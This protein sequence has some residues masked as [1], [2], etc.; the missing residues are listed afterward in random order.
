MKVQLFFVVWFHRMEQKKLT[1]RMRRRT[2]G[3]TGQ[4]LIQ[5]ISTFA[6]KPQFRE[7]A[8]FL[9]ATKEKVHLYMSTD[10]ATGAGGV[11]VS[12]GEGD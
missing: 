10:G 3:H 2:Q 7:S 4:C 1:A 9:H 8:E 12:G 6:T 11:K 5:F